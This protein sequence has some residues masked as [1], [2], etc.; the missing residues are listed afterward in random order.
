MKVK[1][2]NNKTYNLV[3]WDAQDF[4]NTMTLTINSTDLTGIRDTFTDVQLVEILR[5]GVVVATFTEF[6]GYSQ[7]VFMTNVYIED[8]RRFVDA[9]AVTLSK[10]N[11]VDLVKRIDQQI[12]PTYDIEHMTLNEYKTYKVNQIREAVKND[13]FRGVQVVLHDGSVETF[14]LTLED[15][16]NIN[17]LF[18]AILAGNGKV[19][20][21][22][23]H[24]THNLCREYPAQ[25]LVTLYVEMQKAIT[26]KTT[27]ANFAINLARD[28]ITKEELDTIEYGMEF[29]AETEAQIN[30]IITTTLTNINTVLEELGFIPHDETEPEDEPGEIEPED[31]DDEQDGEPAENE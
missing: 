1:V 27:V 10:T 11:I 23:Y 20:E 14:T 15:Q 8:G 22:P 13:I 28:A 18:M 17:S 2:N 30:D 24:S 21:L 16:N 3:R 4:S 26:Y 6:D 31:E 29:D 12:N 9:L 5:D 25:D 19:T 7:I